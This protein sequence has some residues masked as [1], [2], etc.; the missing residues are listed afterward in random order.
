M[1][2]G[3]PASEIIPTNTK[4]KISP[5]TTK[6]QNITEFI[7]TFG[8]STN[9]FQE[10]MGDQ[11]NQ[12]TFPNLFNPVVEKSEGT[13]NFSVLEISRT[14]SLLFCEVDYFD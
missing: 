14:Q 1:R 12:P 13:S 7:S 10:Q 6:Y 8:E 3:N 4:Q 9:Q 5:P 2:D 11:L